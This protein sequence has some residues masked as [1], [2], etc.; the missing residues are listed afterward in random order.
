M[1]VEC[2]GALGCLRWPIQ[3]RVLYKQ[4]YSRCRAILKNLARQL[5]EDLWVRFNLRV[6]FAIGT[7]VVATLK[8]ARNH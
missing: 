8:V 2:T 4:F 5:R 6:R 1:I 7:T 3:L